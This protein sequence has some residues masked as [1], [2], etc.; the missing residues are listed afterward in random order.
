M[1]RFSLTL[2]GLGVCAPGIVG[3]LDDPIA[4]GA[5][6]D[7]ISWAWLAA[8]LLCRDGGGWGRLET[9]QE[10]GLHVTDRSHF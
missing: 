9:C 1:V 3:P 2:S 10:G 5:V 4:A 6:C 8:R 7:P